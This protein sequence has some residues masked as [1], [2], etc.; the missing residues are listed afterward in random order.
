MNIRASKTLTINQNERNASGQGRLA[1]ALK[2]KLLNKAGWCYYSGIL[3]VE[4]KDTTLLPLSNISKIICELGRESVKS[5]SIVTKLVKK[6]YDS[7]RVR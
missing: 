4:G 3:S 2:H 1:L 6:R 5:D 7:G